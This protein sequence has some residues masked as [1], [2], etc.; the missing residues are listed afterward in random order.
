MCFSETTEINKDMDLSKSKELLA[1]IA[2]K[3]AFFK[4]DFQIAKS[5]FIQ[6]IHQK[7]I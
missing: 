5:H 2:Y 3:A 7:G 4:Y 6:H 1:N